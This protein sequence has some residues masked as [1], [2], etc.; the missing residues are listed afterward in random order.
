MLQ[1]TLRD[2]EAKPLWNLIDCRSVKMASRKKVAKI[3]LSTQ[4]KIAPSNSLDIR[5]YLCQTSKADEVDEVNF[6]WIVE[7]FAFFD[8]G[9]TYFNLTSLE[10]EKNF[11][12]K[13]KVKQDCLEIAL[14]CS[15][16]LEYYI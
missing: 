9:Q 2:F 14:L 7:R 8:D 4:S 15:T 11:R 5:S 13:F 1:F 16:T 12:L 10:F 6:K 3:A